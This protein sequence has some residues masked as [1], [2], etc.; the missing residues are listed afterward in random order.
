[1]FRIVEFSR[2][3]L[4]LS[5]CDGCLLAA[6]GDSEPASFPLVEL[7]A[8]LISE[9]AASLSGAVLY[10]L[11]AHRIPLIV[12]DRCA[13]PQ[14]EL[15][16]IGG[17]G[18]DADDLLA[19][20]FSLSVSARGRL[21][22]RIVRAKISGQSRTLGKWRHSDVLTPLCA[23]V[24]NADPDNLEGKAAALYWREL[25]LFARRERG[26]GANA[27][28]NYTYTILYAAFAR[29]IAV[30]GLHPRLG[31]FHHCRDNASP[32][33]SDLM[34]PFRPA[35]DDAVLDALTETGEDVLT[36]AAKAA[37]LR[38]LYSLELPMPAGKRGLFV[39]C[40]ECVQS[41]KRMLLTGKVGNFLLPEW[42][43][44]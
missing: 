9:P 41:Y 37:L 11:A 18:S 17:T 36:S 40:R 23:R 33:A 29:E 10:A 28:F 5:I 12:C 19:A 1:M 14:G 4:R 42:G 35:A 13:M 2:R 38:R 32:L 31:L 6:D 8:V 20:Q 16:H 22:R 15:A 39:G 24:R 27:F 43:V 7:S 26:G 44:A 30:A 21:W 34:E 3:G 25:G